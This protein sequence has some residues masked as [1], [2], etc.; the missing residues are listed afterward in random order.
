MA[1]SLKRIGSLI[2]MGTV[3]IQVSSLMP[4]MHIAMKDLRISI[5]ILVIME[6]IRMNK[7]DALV[8][9]SLCPFYGLCAS[10]Q[11]KVNSE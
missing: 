11:R 4:E 3:A 8:F 1:K 10:E 7:I 9:H 6:I 5:T 2:E